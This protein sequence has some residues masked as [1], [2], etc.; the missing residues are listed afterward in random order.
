M[1]LEEAVSVW[2]SQQIETTRQSYWYPMRDHINLVG[3][4]LP[5]SAVT[6][7]HIASYSEVIRKRD[8]TPKTL[9]KHFK[10]VKTFWN[11]AVKMDLVDKSPAR[12]LKLPKIPLNI[13]REKALPDNDLIVLLNYLRR[14]TNATHPEEYALA[15]RN[16]ALFKFLADTGAR[17]GGA[18]SLMIE[19]VHLKELYAFVTEKG[20]K[21]RKVAFTEE[22]AKA[23]GIWLL[24][25]PYT[26]GVNNVFLSLHYSVG[27]ITSNY[28]GQV[29]RRICAAIKRDL[30]YEMKN[31]NPHSLRHRLG[32]KLFDARVAPSLVAAALGHEDIETAIRHYAPH[33]WESASDAVREQ[34]IDT[35]RVEAILPDK[36]LR[37]S[38][39]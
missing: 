24:R 16:Y 37:L 7:I 18:A 1:K 14:Q 21:R 17:A 28:I 34:A 22:C 31:K 26:S 13:G 38:S 19:D 9:E 3:A 25:R 5:L 12:I 36:V 29:M 32:H 33:D 4:A 23:L 30:G 20:N 10:T 35:S 6:P 39:N 11:W 15:L 8:Y 2:L 27:P